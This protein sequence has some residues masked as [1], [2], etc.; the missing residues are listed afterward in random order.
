M[1]RDGSDDYTLQ[2]A[3]RRRE[4]IAQRTGVALRHVGT[5][6]QDPG[7]LPGNIEHFIGV[8][9]VPLGLAGPLSINGEHAQG[10]FSI[11]VATTEGTLVA[12]YNRG[13]RLLSAAGGVQ[14]TVVDDRMQRGPVFEFAD[15]HKARGF[16][17][18]I[19]EHF[20]EIRAAAGGT[21]RVGRLIV[22]DQDA[23]G[24]CAI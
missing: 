12:S 16:G 3:Q 23:V 8:A 13:M 2:M 9:Q 6:S 17:D 18:L 22:I 20:D 1:P 4:F 19:R 14:V 24:R 21:T 7:Q 10:D 15:A 5:F 11:P